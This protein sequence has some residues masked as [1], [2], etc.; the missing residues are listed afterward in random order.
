[1]DT[2]AYFVHAALLAVGAKVGGPVEF[3]PKYKSASGTEIEVIVLWVDKDG[4]KHQAPAQEWIRHA[5]T[6]KPMTYPWV[7]AGSGFWFDDMSGKEHYQAE[8]GDLICVSNFPSA[9]LD[10]PVESSQSNM[11]LLFEANTAKIPPLKTPIR[12]VLR[13]KV[14]PGEAEESK[15]EEKKE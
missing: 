9:T 10:L 5:E 8:G 7:F 14:K 3:D 6:K 1:M 13:P 12:L 2:K 4:K 11:G 15:K